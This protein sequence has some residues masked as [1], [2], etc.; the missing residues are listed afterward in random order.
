MNL[1][2]L[3]KIVVLLSGG[4]FFIPKRWKIQYSVI[5]HITIVYI[6]G[7]WAFTA[8]QASSPI[9][10]DLGIPFWSGTPSFVIDTLSAFFVFI[11]NLI[12]LTG[13]IYG[14]GYLKPYRNDKSDIA[15]SLHV[16]AFFVLHISMLH[17]VMM[18]EGL[19]F[20]MAWEVMSMSSFLLIIFEGENEATLKT[21]IKY[22]VQMHA[23]FI[24]LLL[25]FLWV[26]QA[27]GIFGFDGLAPYFASHG[28]WGIFLLFF[29]GFGIKAGFVPLHT[30]LPHA[31]PAAPS[32][33]SGVMSG[34]MIKMGVY[35]ILR[36]L[37]Q[38]QSQYLE[39][40]F[41]ILSIS[42]ATALTGI[43][44]AIFQK[45]IKKT[46]AYSSIE[47]IGIIGMGI[48]LS[49]V[50]KGLENELLV[51]L[52][53]AGA[54]LH[55]FNHS[56]YKSLLFYSA[57]SV[58]YA[59]HTRD[60]NKLGGLAN[61]MPV[62]ASMFMISSLAI[63]A[64]PPLNGFVSEFLLY[65]GVFENIALSAFD[66]S[67]INLII[68]LSLIV[69]GGLS[70]FAFTKTFGV[71]FLGS[72]RNSDHHLIVE[73]PMI[74]RIP[75]FII[76]P[77]MLSVSL[78]PNFY[79]SQISSIALPF[80][81]LD[82]S[83]AVIQSTAETLMHI[84]FGNL[85]VIVTFTVIMLIKRAVQ[86]RVVVASGPTWGCGYSA[87]DFRHQYTSTSYAENLRELVGPL[88]DVKGKPTSFDEKEIFPLPR[89]YI[90]DVK[91]LIEEKLVIRPVQ[92]VTRELP[93]AG[94]AQTGM[95]NHYLVY[96]L[97]FLIIII[98]L[99]LIGIL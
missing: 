56:L 40:G 30:W 76:I 95:I 93:K 18:R 73:V 67:L 66:I 94:W 91:D 9:R 68:L 43:L 98:L 77:I 61:L 92:Y 72:R 29:A 97:V 75:G 6:T 28:N 81:R 59:T 24:F 80:T 7:V 85:V 58:Y 42:V 2:L 17:V 10:V 49:F 60:L 84:S 48:G 53:L 44:Y 20:L 8:W 69:I 26:S 71:A 87:G 88:V 47:N 13:I 3:F 22:L 83:S 55:I 5:L 45:N 36:T 41:F 19:A 82:L 27:T 32:H 37:T 50:G 99:T 96:P 74:M 16:W 39:I 21:G 86:E 12:S 79:L 63:C 62:T 51:T 1:I 4:I 25:G 52:G 57:G 64:I 35:G 15:L 33:V 78:F 11:I 23:G 70:V 46:L 38:V 54:L 90:T 34:V 14:L 65:K 31:H 89:H